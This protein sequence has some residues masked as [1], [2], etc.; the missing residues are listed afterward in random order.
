MVKDERLLAGLMQVSEPRFHLLRC[1]QNF[2][3]VTAVNGFPSMHQSHCNTVVYVEFGAYTSMQL[4][5][6][7]TAGV[8]KGGREVARGLKEAV[9]SS[10]ASFLGL[11]MVLRC[12]SLVD[13]G[14]QK[15]DCWRVP[16][17]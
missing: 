7:K 10:E 14:L 3:C 13:E 2:F 6:A 9:P 17:I 15:P 4:Q 5:D 8:S 16:R 1:L 11:G 12:Q